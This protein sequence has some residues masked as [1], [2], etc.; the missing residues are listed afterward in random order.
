ML[1]DFILLKGRTWRER[2]FDPGVPQTELFH[3][4]WC[5]TTSKIQFK[6]PLSTDQSVFTMPRLWA[7]CLSNNRFLLTKNMVLV[8][9]EKGSPGD[10][11]GKELF[12]HQEMLRVWSL[13]RED[14]LEEGKATHSSVLAWRIPGTERLGRLE[15][16]RSHRVGHDWSD[17]EGTRESH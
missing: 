13:G 4:P 9:H 7:N 8:S 3:Y 17:L 14:P 5:N 12:C 16:I 10:A 11:N 6:V 15:T 1:F 2:A